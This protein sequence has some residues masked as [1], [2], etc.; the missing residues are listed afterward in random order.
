MTVLSTLRTLKSED[1]S[2]LQATID[3]VN[4]AKD[5]LHRAGC[6]T[7]HWDDIFVYFAV[8]ALD[9]I[10]RKDWVT[11]L[12]GARERPNYQKFRDFLQGRIQALQLSE[13][14]RVL[15]RASGPSKG[16]RTETTTMSSRPKV[17]TLTNAIGSGSDRG[18]PLP[19]NAQ[20]PCN[21]RH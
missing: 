17:R 20:C 7:E 2:A 15:E 14:S 21:E 13:Q 11:S 3:T 9:P 19:Q 1:S 16:G 18:E 6:K 12:G 5:A 10:T 8:R 4:I